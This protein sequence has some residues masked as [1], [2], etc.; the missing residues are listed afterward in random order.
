MQTSKRS[1]K[2]KVFRGIKDGIRKFNLQIVESGTRKI[3]TEI[4]EK[5]KRQFFI[6]AKEKMSH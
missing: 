2:I 5:I 4:G 1:V 6:A 3:I